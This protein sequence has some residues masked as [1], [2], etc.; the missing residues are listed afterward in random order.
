M[1]VLILCSYTHEFWTYSFGRIKDLNQ[2]IDFMTETEV[3][4]P[5]TR[6]LICSTGSEISSAVRMYEDVQIVKLPS[7]Y[8]LG[9]RSN[10]DIILSKIGN[11]Q[12][13]KLL[14]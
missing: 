5:A 7:Y 13:K 10:I 9:D 3:R 4:T 11:G 2:S 6:Y 1:V 14:S 12:C 8:M